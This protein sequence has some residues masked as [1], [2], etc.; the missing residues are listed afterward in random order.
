MNKS[1]QINE[2][3]A[4]LAKAQGAMRSATKDSDN[5]FFKSKY[6]SLAAIWNSCREH[7]SLNGLSVVQ[8]TSN[9]GD[10]ICVESMLLHSSGQFI[11]SIL[12]VK[13]VKSDIQSIGSAITYA[14]RYAL[15]ALIGISSSEEDDD[16]QE[17]TRQ[18][19]PQ[20]NKQEV[21][22]QLAAASKEGAEAFRMLWRTLPQEARKF[23]TLEL[24][25]QYKANADDADYR[26]KDASHATC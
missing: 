4:A 3:A 16:G 8:T 15:A 7:L 10:V 12:K 5:P 18:S 13:P 2:L 25:E 22:S 26:K 21:L 1:E 17:A 11:S 24:M 20:E 9:E 6:T 23:V 19:G 14:R